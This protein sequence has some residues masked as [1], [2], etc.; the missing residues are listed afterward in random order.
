[1]SFRECTELCQKK[2]EANQRLV[3]LTVSGRCDAVIG[4]HTRDVVGA[5]SSVL[6]LVD[7]QRS[8]RRLEQTLLSVPRVPE[9]HLPA[10]VPAARIVF[11]L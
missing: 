5:G 8:A 1:M 9:L 11:C 6:I 7:L 10:R 2:I 3:T 4:P